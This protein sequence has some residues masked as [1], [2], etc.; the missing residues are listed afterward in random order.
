MKEELRGQELEGM[1]PSRL[2]RYA[3]DAVVRRLGDSDCVVLRERRTASPDPEQVF[4][5][6]RLAGGE[7]V[8]RK[9]SGSV[10]SSKVRSSGERAARCSTLRRRSGSR[11][12]R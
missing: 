2:S 11:R 1:R 5:Y 10:V 4:R 8:M 7:S 9:A 12:R 6:V 3:S